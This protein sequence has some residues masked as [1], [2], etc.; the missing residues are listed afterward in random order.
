MDRTYIEQ[1]QREHLMGKAAK[2]AIFSGD[3]SNFIS[4]FT[5]Q[6]GVSDGFL[7]NYGDPLAAFY[8][9]KSG[10]PIDVNRIN[11]F[12]LTF[13]DDLLI[14][15]TAL[16]TIRDQL[17]LITK[18]NYLKLESLRAQLEQL[19]IT[20]AIESLRRTSGGQWVFLEDFKD[21][22]RLDLANSS[23]W[24]DSRTG[25]VSIPIADTANAIRSDQLELEQEAPSSGGSFINTSSVDCLDG[26]DGTGWLL[27]GGSGSAVWKLKKTWELNQIT[28]DPIGQGIIVHVEAWHDGGWDK[29]CSEVL[30][31]AKTVCRSPMKAE[32]IRITISPIKETCGLRR[33]ILWS[34]S[35]A[36]EA[37]LLSKPYKFEL[38]ISRARL[39]WVADT[40]GGSKTNAYVSSATASGPWIQVYNGIDYRLTESDKVDV[41]LPNDNTFFPLIATKSIYSYLEI[42]KDQIEVSAFDYDW[43]ASGD[44]AHTPTTGDWISPPTLVRRTWANTNDQRSVSQTGT[45]LQPGTSLTADSLQGNAFLNINS[46]GNSS[47]GI[48]LLTGSASSLIFMPGNNYKFRFFVNSAKAQQITD[49]SLMFYAGVRNENGRT[50][51]ESRKPIAGCA[52][53]VNDETIYARAFPNTIFNVVDDQGMLVTDGTVSP[54]TINLREGWNKIEI[55]VSLAAQT[56]ADRDTDDITDPYVEIR[57]YPNFFDVSTVER[58]NII[59]VVA[60]GNFSPRS[61]FD[62]EWSLLPDPTSWAWSTGLDKGIKLN[63]KSDDL[64]VP[65]DGVFTGCYPTRTFT[66][67][68][69][70]AISDSLYVKF[71]LERDPLTYVGPILHNYQLYGT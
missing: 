19:R 46:E 4:I 53:A 23:A 2:T 28:L 42:G 29:F 64:L 1:L 16:I 61:E 20:F 25:S 18:Q 54:T 9:A 12:H 36:R 55:L 48:V 22:T 59:R 34:A 47:L 15:R 11:Q 32:K 30:Y 35:Y 39:S 7:R 41:E 40:P 3:T 10:T 56:G 70:G 68:K 44:I 5:N 21:T 13:R 14:S 17:A 60:T 50:Y 43:R 62:L 65:I 45:I 69:E 51:E 71:E 26:Q 66:Y 27:K 52:L 58:L 37:T 8:K 33:L 6:L 63:S 31:V 57:L 24:I 38:P 49:S 67:L